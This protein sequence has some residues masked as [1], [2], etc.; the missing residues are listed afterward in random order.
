MVVRMRDLLATPG[1]CYGVLY[2]SIYNK[3]IIPFFAYLMVQ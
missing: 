3:K 2:V 1:W